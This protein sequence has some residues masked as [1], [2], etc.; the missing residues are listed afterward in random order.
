MKILQLRFK[1]L[2]SLYGEWLID[3]TAPDYTANGIFAL[4][5]PTGAGKSTILDAICLALYGTTPRLGKITK[6]SNEIMSRQTAECF[7]EVT[8]AAQ[9]GV[10]RCHWSQHRARKNI[11]ANLT[12]TKHEIADADSGQILETKKRQ[13][14][15]V[16]EQKTGMDFERFTRSIL[17]AQGGFDTFLKAD[18]EQKSK[19]L[20]QITGTEIYSQISIAVH[21]RHKNEKTELDRL[22][23]EISAFSLLSCEQEEELSSELIRQQTEEIRF[24]EKL[25]Q[26]EQAINRLQSINN[27]KSELAVFLQQKEVLNQTLES[28]QPE[29][30]QLLHSQQAAELEGEYASLISLRQQQEQDQAA[31]KQKNSQLPEL[32]QSLQITADSLKSS[33]QTTLTG[34]KEQ[35]SQAPLWQQ[36][37]TLDQQIT[38]KQLL[39][40]REETDYQQFS[41]RI[42]EQIKLRTQSN[43]QLDKVNKDLALVDDY[44]TANAVDKLLVTQL[45]ALE[46][47]VHNLN[48][49]QSES[50]QINT[51]LKKITKERVVSEKKRAS[52]SAESVRSKEHLKQAQQQLMVM[53]NEL[54]DLLEGRLL[55]EYRTDKES[56]LREM[57]LLK[58]IDDLNIERSNLQDHKACPLCGSKEHPYAQGNIPEMDDTENKIKFLT[59]KIKKAEKMELAIKDLG[60][61]EQQAT[62]AL[63]AI[64]T[65]IM[66]ANNNFNNADK[67]LNDSK[68]EFSKNNEHF[69]Y[70]KQTIQ[71]RLDEFGIF[72]FDPTTLLLSLKKRL[73]KWQD[74]QQKLTDIS[75]Q[76]AELSSE[77]NKLNAVIESQTNTLNAKKD[78]LSSFKKDYKAQM[79][80][81]KEL[82]A[83]KSPDKEQK[84]LEKA[85]SQAE[86]AEQAARLERDKVKQ[87]VNA[88]SSL[89]A[90]LNKDISKRSTQL[91]SMDTDFIDILHKAEFS[92]EVAF[93]SKRLSI[94]HREQLI[95]KAKELDKQK[96]NL[97]TNIKDREDRLNLEINKKTT[98]ATLDD[99]QLAYEQLKQTIKLTIDTIAGLKH[100]LSN[101]EAIK[102]KLKDKQSSIVAQKK[103]CSKWAKLYELIGSADGKKYRNFAQGLTFELMVSHANRQLEKMTDRYL[104]IRDD[105][106]PL[107]LNVVDNYQAGEI[108]SSKNL[109]GGE[110]FIVSLTLALGLSKMASHK[111]RVDSLFLDEGFGTL[112]EEA[113]E[114]AL[115]TL[116]GLQQD[117]KVIGIISH[118][119]ALK[120][121]ISTQIHIQPLSG[122]KSSILGPGCEDISSR[123][124]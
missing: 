107:E 80:T 110:S 29:R 26:S 41:S 86:S 21:E 17:L 96:T 30:E 23:A 76:Q 66:L 89:I 32:E 34:K 114:T 40:A 45:G 93:L 38:D 77:I 55:R 123:V 101:N 116:S 16:I 56:L 61:Q 91:Q 102:K 15:A 95:I 90:E 49:I 5:G 36:V 60:D 121:R 120:D 118:V 52:K 62:A 75:H 12:E 19:V 28:F 25:T 39:I 85:I 11:Q 73:K 53:Q 57:L 81:R 27:L 122:G 3:F 88:A 14:L 2:N 92:D 24:S 10:F 6:S 7:A 71:E 113:L 50:A 47:Q 83:D 58:K 124:M 35:Q 112:D 65:A 59:Q 1:N 9:S 100:Q 74:Y 103:E 87:I 13:V 54:T 99:L 68:L 78:L 79:D 31:V 117:G 42:K 84:R 51:K 98:Q 72:D 109:S 22:Q 115:E 4:T 64:E 37:R 20:E 48:S 67:A 106:K 18:V 8:F 108:R 105:K 119:S 97:Q 70:I 46:E 43:K 33:E 63:A 69:K 94:Q 82:F 111:V 44:L 104:L